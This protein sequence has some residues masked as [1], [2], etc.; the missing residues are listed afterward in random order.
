MIDAVFTT[1][2]PPAR[3]NVPGGCACAKE[4]AGHVHIH[5]ALPV[6]QRQLDCRPAQ[7]HAG[8]VHEHVDPALLAHDCVESAGDIVFGGHVQAHG[9][10]GWPEPGCGF[11]DRGLV[12]VQQHDARASG[13]EQPSCLLADARAP[14]VMAATRSSIRNTSMKESSGF[15]LAS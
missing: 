9:R 6:G 14:P 10:C 13:H 5:H 8:V 4:H 12:L 3:S 11:R 2:P 7:R 1:T 15:M